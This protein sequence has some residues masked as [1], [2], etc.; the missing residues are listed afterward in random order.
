MV[1]ATLLK[2]ASTA[3]QLIAE[4]VQHVPATR[5]CACATALQSAIITRPEVVPAIVKQELAPII[6]KYM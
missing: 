4:A 5:T 2:N 6:G 3:Q 1:V